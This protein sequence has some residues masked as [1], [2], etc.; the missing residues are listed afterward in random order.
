MSGKTFHIHG[1]KD[2]NIVNMA[3]LPKLIYRFNIIPVRIPD[4]FF[5]EI[6]QLILKFMWKLKGPIKAKTILKKKN[7]VGGL[8]FSDFK[9]YY[10]TT[11]IKPVC[12]W[13]KDGKE[14]SPGKLVYL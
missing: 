11:T 13:H 8:T 6:D 5:L 14:L 3:I 12:Y 4:G 2:L 9:T 10:K 7:K 1:L